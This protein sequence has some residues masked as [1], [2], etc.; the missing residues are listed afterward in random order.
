METSC[1]CVESCSNV[2]DVSTPDTLRRDFHNWLH[3]HIFGGW[4]KELGSGADEE[5]KKAALFVV[6]SRRCCE[7]KKKKKKKEFGM[8]VSPTASSSSS[9]AGVD[10]ALRH[11]P[12]SIHYHVGY[13]GIDASSS[14][15]PSFSPEADRRSQKSESSDESQSS[16][17]S[18][19]MTDGRK[20]RRKGTN[21]YGRPYCPGRPLSMEERT[22]IIELH[23]SGMKVN[24]ISK[25]LCISH[26][27]VSKIISRYRQTGI[28]SPASSP[29][30]RRTRRK[31]PDSPPPAP[32]QPMLIDAPYMTYMEEPG[33]Y[34][35]RMD[36]QMHYHHPMYTSPPPEPLSAAQEFSILL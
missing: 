25:S 11:F 6:G 5:K 20:S 4:Q 7:A 24:A 33:D 22:R 14:T 1:C 28:L 19:A 15:S 16:R 35:P 21:L 10:F 27:C 2:I 18:T 30:Q 13:P 29:E 8:L 9:L 31:K 26:G 23:T 3:V 17:T 32:P 36:Y 34:T 12:Q